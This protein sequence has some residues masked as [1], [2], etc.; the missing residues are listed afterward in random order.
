MEVSILEI[1][2]Y[3][4]SG[5]LK[6][7]NHLSIN[8]NFLEK[9]NLHLIM[10]MFFAEIDHGDIWNVIGQMLMTNNHF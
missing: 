1:W 9:I 3:L 10:A 5:G 7:H 6:V 2:I 4:N 8:N